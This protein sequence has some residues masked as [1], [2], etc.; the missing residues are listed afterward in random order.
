MNERTSGRKKRTN[1]RKN[2]DS[3]SGKKREKNGRMSGRKNG[4]RRSAHSRETGCSRTDP[5]IARKTYGS[6]CSLRKRK[7][8]GEGGKMRIEEEK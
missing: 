7:V 1:S 3:R 5:T 2:S 4:K 6:S 8:E